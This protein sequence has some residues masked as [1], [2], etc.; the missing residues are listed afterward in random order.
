MSTY[1]TNPTLEDVKN[2]IKRGMPGTSMRAYDDF[3]ESQLELLAEEVLRMRRE[4]VRER[5]VAILQAEEEEIDEE[6]VQEVVDLHSLPGELVQ[7]PTIGSADAVSITRG[8]SVY[9]E[10][11]CRPCHGENGTGESE[12]PLFNEEGQPCWSRDLVND[13]FK[14]GH[15]PESIYLRI[16]AGMPGSPHPATTALT[17]QQY[18]DLV[19]FCGSLSREP[20]RTLTN[21]QRFLEATQ[22]PLP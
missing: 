16:L 15:E 14:G 7:V 9:L 21:H 22:R 19:Q 4:G 5:F 12:I 11:G 3:T 18:V 1:S 6:E 2:A 17:N 20:K 13:P 10:T 8:R